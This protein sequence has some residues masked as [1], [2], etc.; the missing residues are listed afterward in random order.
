MQRRVL[1]VQHF[2]LG[3][4][5]ALRSLR[6]DSCAAPT[7]PAACAAPPAR[8][9]QPRTALRCAPRAAQLESNVKR[10]SQVYEEGHT[11]I[12]TWGSS[13]ADLTQ[14]HR[15]L[16][17]MCQAQRGTG[18]VVV[19]LIQARLALCSVQQ[20]GAGLGPLPCCLAPTTPTAAGCLLGP[21]SYRRKAAS[22]EALCEPMPAHASPCIVRAHVP[23][24][25]Q[26]EKLEMERLFR[27]ALPPAKRHGTFFVF[28][29]VRGE[30]GAGASGG[31][32]CCRQPPLMGN[33]SR[34]TSHGLAGC[35]V[36]GRWA[37]QNAGEPIHSEPQQSCGDRR[38]D[39][40]DKS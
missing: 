12:A 16:G 1:L 38:R 36:G 26:R 7:T 40:R 5:A 32:N 33:L 11:V 39:E 20:A 21:F 17:Q 14:L 35:H 3:P 30:G 2:E 10:G 19:C 23:P 13:A 22:A 28:R 25:Q 9:F 34:P 31:R 15:M 18:G 4:L 37:H 29:Q 27:D 6:C 8:P 24:V